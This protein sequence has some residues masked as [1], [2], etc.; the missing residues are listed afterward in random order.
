MLRQLRLM[1]QSRQDT[2]QMGTI[3]RI[4][5][6]GPATAR[7]QVYSPLETYWNAF[8]EWRKRE[9][10]AYRIGSPDGQRAYGHRYYARMRSATSP[11]TIYRPDRFLFTLKKSAIGA[12]TDHDNR[13]SVAGRT[14]SA[15]G[16]F[17]TYRSSRRMS[18][19]RSKAEVSWTSPK[20]TRSK[21]KRTSELR[22]WIRLA[23]EPTP[24]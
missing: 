22:A 10:A 11:Q 18:A 24:T 1:K 5:E 16:T 7:R 4:T 12:L 21:A 17:R 14:T 13:W 23:I 2:A 9:K 8:Q 6:L 15:P 3:H 20:P 19:T